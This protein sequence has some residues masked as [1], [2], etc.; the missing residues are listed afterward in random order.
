MQNPLIKYLKTAEG[1]M[2]VFYMEHNR[3]YCRRQS[4]EGLQPPLCIA[5][6]VAAFSL[7]EY[8]GYVYL[9]YPTTDGRLQLAASIDL[10]HWQ[11]RPLWQEGDRRWQNTACFMI[12][13]KDALHLIYAHKEIENPYAILEYSMFQKGRWQ[14]H[15]QISSFLPMIGSPFLGR[16]LGENHI[17]LYYRIQRNTICAR[18]ILLSPFTLGSPVPLLQMNGQCIDISILEDAQTIHMLYIVRN[19]F[20]TQVVYRY[21]RSTNVSRPYVVWEGGNCENCLLYQ[22]ENHLVL[23]WTVG[24]QPMRCT[25]DIEQNGMQSSFFGP[26]E[27]CMFPF[28]MQCVKG[29]LISSQACFATEQ[30]G[31]RQNGYYPVLWGK[32]NQP[33]MEQVEIQ[34]ASAEM[35]FTKS[36]TEEV[37]EL[38]SLLAQRSEE[39]SAVNAKWSAQ[40]EHLEKKLKDLEQEIQNKNPI[41][42]VEPTDES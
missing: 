2:A 15:Y 37:E 23:F 31:D 25:C 14:S 24:M 17:I 36:D 11:N 26:I 1:H 12:P 33:T 8:E 5:E 39:I 20:R 22:E 9:L 41:E 4:L 30:L 10:Q 38:R 6:G 19:L 28:P 13:Q 27:N 7:C 29:E 40:V 3:V 21:K 18:E 34:A 35:C 16:R 42:S 32:P